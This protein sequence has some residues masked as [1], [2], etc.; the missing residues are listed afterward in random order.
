MAL[1]MI[2]ATALATSSTVGS[3][4]A[5]KYQGDMQESYYNFLA[6]QSRFKANLLKKEGEEQSQLI[7][8]QAS[9]LSKKLSENVRKT[10]STQRSAM[11]SNGLDLGSV[12]AEDL[13]N[14]TIHKAS[15]DDMIIR[16]NADL[17]AYNAKKNA[18]YSSFD[19]YAQGAGQSLAG[20][21]YGA[22]GNLGATNTLLS[23]ASQTA[24]N[25]YQIGQYSNSGSAASAASAGG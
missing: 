23:G 8:Y 20:Q 24:L 7:Q 2:A 1:M 3:A 6:E 13:I 10:E 12:T 11:I 14:D 22:A 18:I 25:A 19:A 9:Q 16:Y 17:A 15:L 21:I 5:Q 4:L